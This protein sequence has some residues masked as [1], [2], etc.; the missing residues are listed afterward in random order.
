MQPILVE[1]LARAWQRYKQIKTKIVENVT[2]L[3]IFNIF[4][5][6]DLFKSTFK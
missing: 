3:S 1:W 5:M 2:I 4:N 6:E